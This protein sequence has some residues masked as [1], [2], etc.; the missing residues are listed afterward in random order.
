MNDFAKKISKA[1]IKESIDEPEFSYFVDNFLPNL[2]K[3]VKEGD[4]E[5]FNV[6]TKLFM[7]YSFNDFN[8]KEDIYNS[9]IRRFYYQLIDQERY[10]FMGSWTDQE[11]VEIV[12]PLIYEKMVFIFNNNPELNAL[13][14]KQK[15]G[16]K[17]SFFITTLEFGYF[18][19]IG[20]L[21]DDY[22]RFDSIKEKIEA[23][24]YYSLFGLEL[25]VDGISKTKR[26]TRNYLPN[27]IYT[28]EMFEYANNIYNDSSKHIKQDGAILETLKKFNIP[29]NKFDSFRVRWG[30]YRRTNSIKRK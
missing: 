6:L 28:D 14:Q 27:R 17:E 24:I 2:K 19:L 8:P 3:C 12:N 30:I 1:L 13:S 16:L 9:D 10:E 18:N 20:M 4:I 5:S 25:L 11:F 26:I 15:D 21:K 22:E 29:I 7:D 23:Y